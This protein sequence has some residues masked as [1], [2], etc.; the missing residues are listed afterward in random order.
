MVKLTFRQFRIFFLLSI[1][2]YVVIDQAIAK[3]HARSWSSTLTVVIYP[4]NGDASEESQQTINALSE[5]RFS[6]IK[7]FIKQ[8]SELYGISI[9]QPIEIKLAPQVNKPPALPEFD[10]GIVGAMWWS[11]QMRWWAWYENS[12]SGSKDIRLFV[13]YHADESTDSQ[14]SVGLEK[15]MIAFIKNYADDRLIERNNFIIAHEMLHT[16]GASD[17]YDPI[18]LMPLYPQGYAAPEL[19]KN[20]KQEQCEIMGGRI[21]YSSELAVTPNSLNAC[22]I[23]NMTAKEIGW[24]K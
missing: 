6:P 13:E 2:I 24:I 11:L 10:S 15:G 8:Q 22:L 23:G 20:K 19:G 16:L 9:H 4:I 5:A 1:L 7:Q 17:K 18:T 12:Y 14:I 21:P 3:H